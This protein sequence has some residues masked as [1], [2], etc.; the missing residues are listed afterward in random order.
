MLSLLE[1]EHTIG[2]WLSILYRYGQSYVGKK[3][4]AYNIGSGQYILMMVLYRNG[5]ISQEELSTYLKVDKGS[6]AKS[7]KKLQQEGY[8]ERKIDQKDK[9]AYQLFLTPKAL[10]IIPKVNEVIK[11]WENIMVSELSD[12]E[13]LMAEQL[14]YKMASKVDSIIENEEL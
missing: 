11:D 6:I 10:E 1:G 8:L 14:L 3:L 9:R 13:K 5:G 12:S 7:V 2:R 4:S